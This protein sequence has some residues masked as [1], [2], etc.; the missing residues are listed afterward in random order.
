MKSLEALQQQ[1]VCVSA[2]QSTQFS[3][4]FNSIWSEH[5]EHSPWFN[6]C[7][8]LYEK[9]NT[10]C[11]VSAFSTT[12]WFSFPSSCLGPVFFPACVFFFFFHLHSPSGFIEWFSSL[13]PTDGCCCCCWSSHCGCS[14]AWKLDFAAEWQTLQTIGGRP[15]DRRA[16][17][18]GGGQF[19]TEIV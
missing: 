4:N 12:N 9:E 14:I 13:S 15:R 7:F 18:E 19:K 8:W 5:A 6:I 10:Y 2:W 16:G 3:L 11:L 1:T 17:L